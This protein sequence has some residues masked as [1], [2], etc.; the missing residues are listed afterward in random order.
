MRL[1]KLALISLI[2]FFVVI[3]AMSLLFPSHIRISKAVTISK[4]SDSVFYLINDFAQ[5][6]RWHPAFQKQNMDSV[7]QKNKISLKRIVRTDS[8]VTLNWQQA[9]KLPVVNSWQI[10]RFG[11]ADSLAL[12]WYMD[13][14]LKWYP[15]QKFGSLFYENTYGRLMEQGLHNIKQIVQQKDS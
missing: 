14:E 15:W 5:W 8:L 6:P 7:L 13:F 2:V 1:I 11:T 4:E 3:T 12:Q 9:G 10:H